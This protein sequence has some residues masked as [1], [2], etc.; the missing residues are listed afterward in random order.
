MIT[1][2]FLTWKKGTLRFLPL[3]FMIFEIG[4][5]RPLLFL[6]FSSIFFFSKNKFK[7]FCATKT[8]FAVSAVNQ[9]S[10]PYYIHNEYPYNKYSIFCFLN[11]LFFIPSEEVLENHLEGHNF[12]FFLFAPR[13][14]QLGL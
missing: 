5:F 13:R 6:P 14:R 7:Y 10:M 9:L 4:N 3:L 8:P 11:I 2:P 12:C 1:C